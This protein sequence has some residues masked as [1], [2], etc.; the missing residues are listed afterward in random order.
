MARGRLEKQIEG[1]EMLKSLGD[2]PEAEQGLR[3]ALTERNNYAVSKAAAAV[4]TLGL[5]QLIPEL[6]AAYSRFFTEDDPQCWAKNALSKA[7]AE[8][9]Y[10]DPDPYLRGLAHIQMEA[11]YGGRTDTAGILRG[12]CALALVGCRSVS[13]I[14]LLR[15]LTPVLLD[16]LKATRIEA[17]RAIVRIG[18]EEGALLLRL[19]ALQ[20]DADPE[21][22]GMVFSAIIELERRDGVRFVAQFLKAGDQTAE[23]A[24]LSLGESR[25]SEALEVLKDHLDNVRH[26]PIRRAVITAIALTRLT[27]GTDFLMQLIRREA[28][29]SDEAKQALLDYGVLS[30]ADRAW[31]QTV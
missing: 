22:I 25:T 15:I 3:K 9:G 8:L 23:E 20:G 16:P 5:R 13:S 27:D 4:E 1:I 12:N 6:V 2:T 31:L 26:S 7:L 17:T 11:V 24:A 19:R 28:V 21:V 29:G 14:E 10:E 30:E 18:R